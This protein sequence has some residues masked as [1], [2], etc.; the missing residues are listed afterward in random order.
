M[1]KIRR[2]YSRRRKGGR[3]RRRKKKGRNKTREI[4]GG[5]KSGFSLVGSEKVSSF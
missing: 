5:R 4:R 1:R 3:R 2:N